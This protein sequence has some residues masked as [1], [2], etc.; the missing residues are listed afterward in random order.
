MS[1]GS[2]HHARRLVAQPGVEARGPQ[3]G[4]FHGVGIGGD[5]S[6]R[7]QMGLLLAAALH[8][9][10]AIQRGDDK[11]ADVDRERKIIDWVYPQPSAQR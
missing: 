7:G 8:L 9:S 5:D 3:I 2:A 6:H 11:Q 1:L 4:R 10:I